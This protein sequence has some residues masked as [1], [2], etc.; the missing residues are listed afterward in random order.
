MAIP[1]TLPQ[2]TIDQLK[3]KFP[4]I[5]E[6]K[7]SKEYGWL[8]SAAKKLVEQAYWWVVN[9]TTSNTNT[10]SSWWP[11]SVYSPDIAYQN[12]P[13]DLAPWQ[14]WAGWYSYTA[15]N[16][17][18]YTINL[19]NWKY[20]FDWWYW[21][22]SFGSYEDAIASINSWNK[23]WPVQ[24]W[25]GWPP[26]WADYWNSTAGQW[27]MDNQ[28]NIYT[29]NISYD[30][31]MWLDDE[32]AKSILDA[33][34]SSLRNVQAWLGNVNS[35]LWDLWK[36]LWTTTDIMNKKFELQSKKTDELAWVWQKNFL[37][38]KTLIE[39]VKKQWW[40]AY[41]EI[42]ENIQKQSEQIESSFGEMRGNL[43]KIEEN[44]NKMA[45]FQKSATWAAMEKKLMA[46]WWKSAVWR[47]ANAL[48]ELNM[49]SDKNLADLQ[50]KL[51]EQRNNLESQYLSL[52]NAIMTDTN[53]T[54]QNKLSFS[55]QIN[56]M[57]SNLTTSATAKTDE[58]INQQYAPVEEQVNAMS[59]LA[60]QESLQKL[61]NAWSN[62]PTKRDAIV[63]TLIQNSF[64]QINFSPDIINKF[65]SAPTLTEGL[66]Q[67]SNYVKS[68][69]P[70]ATS[71]SASNQLDQI[72]ALTQSS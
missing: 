57:L 65:K 32:W 62:D 39:E 5:E 28:N 42:L 43:T 23:W 2:S 34:Q 36:W 30:D 41:T 67:L 40:D 66:R 21:E 61:Q 52:K 10:P 24:Y 56:S 17:K 64:W 31:I 71:S 15:P 25:A 29:W 12:K 68:M 54:K 18:K 19:K 13:W 11:D 9:Q 1:S 38:Q 6:F 44:Y 60:M 48:W 7:A 4:T 33:V 22:K 14:S 47:M 49:Q 55:T 53:L 26:A 27:A 46:Q 16:G 3:Q 59:S 8:G 51:A 72:L 70:T 69:T 58:L 45:E 35:S 20:V 37:D 50:V 63:Q